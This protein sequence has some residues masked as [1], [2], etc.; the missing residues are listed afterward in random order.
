M[1]KNTL[2]VV[3]IHKGNSWYLQE[4]IDCLIRQGYSNKV[5]LIGD[6]NNNCFAGIVQHI[7][8][9]S[10]ETEDLLQFR[11]K[12]IHISTNPLDYERFC[13]ERWFYLKNYVQNFDCGQF[14]LIDSDVL[15]FAKPQYFL[16]RTDCDIMLT[17]PHNPSII[18]FRN[19]SVAV[20]IANL[21]FDIY[22]TPQII[23][24]QHIIQRQLKGE[25]S[26][27]GA[28][29]RASKNNAPH[30]SDMDLLQEFF[31]ICKNRN[32]S[33]LLYNKKFNFKPYLFEAPRP[34]NESSEPYFCSNYSVIRNDP[35]LHLTW[36][37]SKL[38]LSSGRE[39][40]SL[41]FQSTHGKK[42]ISVV[43]SI[44]KNTRKASYHHP[45]PD[46]INISL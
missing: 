38:H 28:A 44:C 6:D 18:Y 37:G 12:Y 13:F 3:I 41:H 15:L 42:F 27:Q 31:L 1:E 20:E 22:D 34:E 30:F 39:I 35:S 26:S 23:L 2:N 29:W 46:S 10:L 4:T 32:S 24:T 16:S 36:N 45:S 17:L 43:N 25:Y 5:V 8:I 14:I 33:K 7:N 40:G 9:K 21:I 11:D 19:K